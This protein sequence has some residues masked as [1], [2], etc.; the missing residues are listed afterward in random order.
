MSQKGCYDAT[1]MKTNGLVLKENH[2]IQTTGIKGSEGY[3]IAD[4]RQVLTILENY[5]TQLYD[6]ANQ[7]ENVGVEHKEE[8]YSDEKG[9]YTAP[10]LWKELSRR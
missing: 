9:P 2:E 8:E 6:Q 3:I 7:Q 5:I 4:Q 10:V 1:Y